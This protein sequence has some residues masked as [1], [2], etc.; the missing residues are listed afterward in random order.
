M[1]HGI[2]NDITIS[3]RDI[4]QRRVCYL[5][6]RFGDLRSQREPTQLGPVD[7]TSLCVS[8]DTSNRT[9]TVH[10]TNTTQTNN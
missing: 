10:K 9:S 2:E 1:S 5:K 3:I 8:P 6:R 4:V 7:R